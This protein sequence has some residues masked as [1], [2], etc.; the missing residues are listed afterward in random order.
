MI[1]AIL[2]FAAVLWRRKRVT[3]SMV[4]D[5]RIKRL[6]K[7]YRKDSNLVDATIDVSHIRLDELLRAC[8]CNS[9]KDLVR[10]KELDDRALSF[11]SRALADTFDRGQFDFFLHSYVRTEFVASYYEDPTVTSK[12]APES[13]PPAKIPLPEGTHW[14]SVRPQDGQEHYEAYDIIESKDVEEVPTFH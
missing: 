12:P 14:V 9:D 5:P 11:F 2:S 7:R 4:S 1:S 3:Q 13:G 10:P 6:L 8:S